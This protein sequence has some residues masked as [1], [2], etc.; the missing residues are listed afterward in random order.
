MVGGNEFLTPNY[1]SILVDSSV[2][3]MS[4][5][6]ENKRKEAQHTLLRTALIIRTHEPNY[7]STLPGRFM[8]LGINLIQKSCD[9]SDEKVVIAFLESAIEVLETVESLYT[10]RGC[11]QSMKI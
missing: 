6:L 11:L 7:D 9:T 10:S 1:L 5:Q 4:K 2:P 3:K 8:D